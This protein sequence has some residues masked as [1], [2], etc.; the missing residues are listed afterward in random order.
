M[1]LRTRRLIL[2]PVKKND[3]P[4]I[5][6]SMDLMLPKKNKWDGF[7]F[8]WAKR[9]NNSKAFNIHLDYVKKA[10]KKGEAIC[11]DIFLKKEKLWIGS[12]SAFHVKRGSWQSAI[13]DYQ[14]HNAFW[15]RGYAKEALN[16]FINFSF[17][18]LKL[19]R[20]EAQIDPKNKAS[21][22][23][24]KSLR[25]SNEGIRRSSV[26]DKIEKKWVDQRIFAITIEDV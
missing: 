21:I 20:L 5:S 4:I 15:L 16:K 18:D 19:H 6:K 23:L 26:F 11:L 13:L 25:M 24:C 17:S 1:E 9:N 8:E 22:A 10:T 14:C 3:F 7:N 12:I 2:R